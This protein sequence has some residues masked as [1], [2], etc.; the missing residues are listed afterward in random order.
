LAP[1]SEKPKLAENK[2]AD[3]KFCGNCQG[4]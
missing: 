1:V 3:D 4:S 2:I